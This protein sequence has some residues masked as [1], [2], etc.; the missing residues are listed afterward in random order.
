M[1]FDFIYL[2]MNM[3]IFNLVNT[4]NNNVQVKSELISPVSS[5]KHVTLFGNKTVQDKPHLSEPNV[6]ILEN[7]VTDVEMSQ[8]SN[9]E[10]DNNDRL[11]SYDCL[12]SNVINFVQTVLRTTP[13]V[14]LSEL[15]KQCQVSKFCTYQ[16]S[17]CATIYDLEISHLL[18][19]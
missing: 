18:I 7:E 9:T 19:M 12:N 2:K 16:S 10:Q 8:Q 13:I 4:S 6:N 1:F 3:Y 14:A 15:A 5:P 17:Y 11:E